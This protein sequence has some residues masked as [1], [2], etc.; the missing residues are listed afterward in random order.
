MRK[1]G[2]SRFPL[3]IILAVAVAA[4]A[5]MPAAVA[6]TVTGTI[7]GTVTD[8]TGAVVVDA[9]VTATNQSTG[10]NTTTTTNRDGAYNLQFLPIGTYTITANSPGFQT[11]SIGP[12]TLEIDQTAKIDAMLKVGSAAATVN[13]SSEAPLL[14]T[15][16]ETLGATLP[17]ETLQS[18]PMNGLNF[19]FATLFVPGAVDPSLAYMGSYDGN[20]RDVDWLGSPS[21]NGNRG[22]ANN[23]VL[24]GVEMNETMNNLA[25]YNIA[26]D[27]IQEM[28]VITAN[29]NAEYGNVN[30]GEELIVTRGGTNR[31]HGSAYDYFQNDA[32]SANSWG[33]N[34]AGIPLGK[35]T[36]DQ[37]GATIGGPILRDRLFFFGDYLGFR[38]HSSGEAALTVPDQ[39]MRNGDFSE[40]LTPQYG[41]IQ[42]YNNQN[43][44]GFANATPYTNNQIPV[45]NPVA[46]FLFA[47]P[48]LYPLPNA[49]PI[50]GDGDLDNY[51]GY[52]SG[53]THNNQ[54]DIRVDYKA[55]SRDSIMS[56]YTIG[57]AYDFPV[58]AAIVVLFPATND[59]PFQN[60]VINWVHTFSP[61]MINE[62]RAGVSR[63]VWAQ[64]I[65]TDTSGVF[66]TNGDNT[67]GIP[68]PNQAFAGFSYMNFGSWESNFGTQAIANEFHENNF[69]YG[70]TLSWQRGA[71][72]LK[73]GAQIIRYQ[74]NSF[75][76]GNAGALGSF[77]YSGQYTEDPNLGSYGYG[78]ADFLMD[79]ST[80]AQVGGV[81]GPTGQRQYRNAYFA[82]DD[83][84]IRSNLTLNVGLRYAHDQPIYEVNNKES[85][86]N[87]A[88]PQLGIAGIEFAGQDGNS[89]ALYKPYWWEFMPRVGFAWQTSPRFVL[90]GG[91]GITDNF[92]GMGS[93]LRLTQNAPFL[94]SFSSFP[95]P[96]TGSSSGQTPLPVENG[97]N[98]SPSALSVSYF[99][100]NAWN[101]HLRPALIQQFNLAW[102]YLIDSKT[103][104]QLG[105]VGEI[106]QHLVVPQQ[107][108]QY[109]NT[110]TGYIADGD[111]SGTI[112][113]PAP[114]CGLVGN[115]GNLFETESE[116]FSNYNA[117][118]A[119][120][121]RRNA[122]G[123][124]F[125]FNYTWSRGMTDNAGFYG[126]YGVYEP[127]SFFQNVYNPK[128][129]YGPIGQ[130]TRNAFNGY[131]VY[132]LPFGR[133][134]KF[135]SDMSRLADEAI[136]GWK[137]S[138]DVIMYSGF[139]LTINSPENY[140]VNSFAAHA[141]YFRPLRAVHRTTQNW[142]GTDPSAVP[143]LNTDANGNT[144]DN[145]SCAYGA[146]SYTG[147]GN[148]QNGSERAPGFRQVDLSAFKTFKVTESQTLELRGE[149]F[150]ALNIAS[151]A[152]P[153]T[154]VYSPQYG[155]IT[156]TNSSQR[157]MQV[158]MHYRF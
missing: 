65:P 74:Q 15:Q 95:T 48:N 110:A 121:H 56:R 111:C 31:F 40:L 61:S 52:A 123:L 6:Q 54:G 23:Y 62:F 80:G 153:N 32:L 148:A 50:A 39:A 112:A 70:D 114:F 9:H 18:L 5:C 87:L 133:G 33:N 17:G 90:R 49:T 77:A 81:A 43:G 35:F 4:I 158:S 108:D 126:V 124:E 129:D 69:F 150:N 146:E 25:A 64:A 27:A 67:V 72:S 103:T 137:V 37:F 102:Q 1:F 68:F 89:R 29:A 38:Y 58:H 96:P 26:P 138:G 118:Q 73:F 28:R 86:V 24:D 85:N 147:F 75:Y 115:D 22:Q 104:A 93:N 16:D 157:V 42:L 141:I 55:G 134:Q 60:F 30:G 63:T 105:Y 128:G 34:F 100:Y 91:Y 151:Y 131:W 149:A 116:A 143:C 145:G 101:P 125:T 21:F 94:H 19:Q 41:D 76:P 11:L 78:F 127:S 155:L 97:F 140:Y 44:A 88:E 117:M 106:G 130:D 144:I 47:H 98:L 59:Y 119:T 113:P 120:L 14:Q 99:N 83:W 122:N 109:S 71:H 51:D 136:G 82:Q 20:E 142:F 13:V 46:K 57:D 2:S 92:E 84:R 139:P 79:Q 3:T 66:G 156:G 135:G 10:V 152:P 8:A 36:Q 7:R 12:F 154:Y 45:V 132:R 107:D 53:Q